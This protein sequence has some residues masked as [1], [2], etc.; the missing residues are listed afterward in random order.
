M[1]ATTNTAAGLPNS[2]E[3]VTDGADVPE[4]GAPVTLLPTGRAD[5]LTG[6]LM[7]W[8]AEPGHSAVDAIADVSP[9]QASSIRGEKVW[10]SVRTSGTNR[11]LAFS[12]EALPGD[13]PHALRL[14]GTMLAREP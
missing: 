13:G 7:A 10:A 12:A 11:L 2:A 8:S 4:P 6:R 1:E 3:Q 9:Y 5:L 14:A